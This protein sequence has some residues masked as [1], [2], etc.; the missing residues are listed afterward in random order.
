MSPGSHGYGLQGRCLAMLVPYCEASTQHVCP[1]CCEV[2]VFFA[3]QASD[4]EVGVVSKPV[5]KISSATG[6]HWSDDPRT[7]IL[8]NAQ[9]PE[10]LLPAIRS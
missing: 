5:P 8:N 10:R 1:E 3:A 4:I 7:S 9:V 6:P 2:I